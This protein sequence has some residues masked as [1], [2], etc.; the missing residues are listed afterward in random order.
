MRA[1]HLFGV[2]PTPDCVVTD[3]YIPRIP[4]KSS[5][6][7][8]MVYHRYLVQ[9][10][11]RNGKSYE[12]PYDQ[13][14]AT[15]GYFRLITASDPYEAKVTYPDREILEVYLEWAQSRVI[16]R[17][18][19]CI[20]SPTHQ[21]KP[22]RPSKARKLANGVAQAAASACA[23][24][25]ST[26]S[27]LS[28]SLQLAKDYETL[29]SLWILCVH[30][31]DVTLADTVMSTLQNMVRKPENNIESFFATVT[32]ELVELLFPK[33]DS[34]KVKLLVLNRMIGFIT[35]TIGQFASHRTIAAILSDDSY[36]PT[37]LRLLKTRLVAC[38][39]VHILPD[40]IE[41][42]YPHMLRITLPS[43]A[44]MTKSDNEY[45]KVYERYWRLSAWSGSELRERAVRALGMGFSECQYH[46]HDWYTVC[47]PTKIQTLQQ[48]PL[49]Q[50][51]APA[52]APTHV[53]LPQSFWDSLRRVD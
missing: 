45:Q 12:V 3:T 34:E 49:T 31:D 17:R 44:H 25:D 26:N 46:L 47:W 53:D 24:E 41:L 32:P 40:D 48:V 14:I 29:I 13:L 27:A 22:G 36:S 11:W 50:A 16:L 43:T 18:E 19:G 15:S 23:G 39:P 42:P 30:I 37:F 6:P 28:D 33:N 38:I 2:P 8:T 5:N 51:P 35:V 10:S 4:T 21:S 20:G 1:T 7:T 9:N 52:S